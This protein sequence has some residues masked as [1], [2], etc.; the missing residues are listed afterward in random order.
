[1]T[2]KLKTVAHSEIGYVRKN[3]QDSG[4]VSDTMMMVADGMGGAAAGDVAS[5]IAIDELYKVDDSDSTGEDMLVVLEDAV[6]RANDRISRLIERDRSY[7]GMG[8]TVC[9]ALFDG[10][11]LG[12]IHLGDSRGYLLRSGELTRITHDHS[13]V[14]SLIDDG[15]IDESEA[16]THPHRSLLLKVL[17]GQLEAD[18]DLFL[19]DVF[20]G[21]RIMFCSD[22]LSGLVEDSVIAQSMGIAERFEALDELVETAHIAGGTDNI[23]IVLADLVDPARPDPGAPQGP[24]TGPED[25]L[26]VSGRS[27]GHGL[28]I[29]AAEGYLLHTKHGSRLPRTDPDDQEDG[30][31]QTS[32]SP[33]ELAEAAAGNDPPPDSDTTGDTPSPKARSSALAKAESPTSTGRIVAETEPAEP[34]QRDLDEA[35]TDLDDESFYQPRK[36]ASKAIIGGVIALLIGIGLIMWGANAY[37]KTQYYVGDDSGQVAIYQGFP[38]SVLGFQTNSLYEHTDIAM[39]DLPAHYRDRV[40]QG[41]ATDDGLDGARLTVEELRGQAEFCIAQRGSATAT[42]SAATS[43]SPAAPSATTA[44]TEPGGC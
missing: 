34:H 32:P 12:V 15:R 29:G 24:P 2:L 44:T 16:L 3:N 20:P 31:S 42:P 23:T 4:Y 14:Q 43:A 9:G 19:F 26:R 8:T 22:G 6:S 25:T 38:G 5:S 7:D 17:N 27:L 41:I 1:M 10:T 11:Q 21:D 28:V 39:A 18:P 33:L 36:R 13:W 35:W 30:V 40:A 37:A